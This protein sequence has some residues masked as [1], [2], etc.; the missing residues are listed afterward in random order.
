MM[1]EQAGSRLKVAT[2]QDSIVATSAARTEI[3][4]SVEAIATEWERLADAVGASPFVRPGWISAWWRAFGSGTL[5]VFTARGSDGRLSGVLPL[6]RRFGALR[7]T[8]NWHSPEFGL[9]AE[10]AATADAMAREILRRG[11]RSLSLRFLNAD[12]G[13]VGRLRAAA[14]AAGY[15]VLERTVAR[16]PY[17]AIEGDWTTYERGLKGRHRSDVRRQLRRLL[18]AGS[19]SVEVATGRERLDELLAEGFRVEPSGWKARESTAI[20]SRDD[21]RQFYSEVAC[22]AARSGFLRLAF[23]RLDGRAIA[24]QYGLEHDGVYY[25]L[26]GGYDV[27]Y[28]RF[29]PGKLLDGMMLERAFCLGMRLYEFLGEENQYTLRW[30]STCRER[31]VVQAFARSASG[32]AE[33]IVV[34]HGRPIVKRLGGDRAL[35]RLRRLR[36]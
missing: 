23:L 13:D 6:Q 8:T 21:T 2:Q 16:S 36:L 26:K 14:D 17:V 32:S 15:R 25:T 10:D 29:S 20:A 35:R 30:T 19:V 1:S 31:Q 9:V 11:E 3:V 7:S 22:W 12:S 28:G 27:E 5:E 34:A 33:W 24:F 4:G 18:E